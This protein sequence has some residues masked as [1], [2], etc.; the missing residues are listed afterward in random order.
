[1]IVELGRLVYDVKVES[2]GEDKKS[3]LNNRIAISQGKDKSTF[4]DIVAWGSTAELIGK[5]FKK[6]YEIY[7]EGHFINKTRKKENI[8]FETVAINIDNIKFTN[9]NPK[10]FTGEIKEET[11]L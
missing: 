2:V 7:I 11:F 4:V 9:G 5:F 6:G 10:E 8:E 3:V 1:M